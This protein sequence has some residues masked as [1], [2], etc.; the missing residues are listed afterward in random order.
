MKFQERI[1]KLV[2]KPGEIEDSSHWALS[3]NDNTTTCGGCGS[4]LFYIKQELGVVAEENDFG[5]WGNRS[6]K[7][8]RTY[9]VREIGLTLYCAECGEYE[10]TYHNFCYDKDTMVC[11]WDE[12]SAVEKVEIEYCLYQWNQ[13]GDFKPQWKCVEANYLKKKLK[14]YEKKHPLKLEKRRVKKKKKVKGGKKK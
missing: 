5:I 12:L 6:N 1:P 10:E 8:N 13:K 9:C 3:L 4:H 2:I 14:E 11:T 7:T